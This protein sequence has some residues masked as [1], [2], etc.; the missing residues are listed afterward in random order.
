MQ[1]NQHI[2]KYNVEFNRL[3]IR[4]GWD[5]SVLRHRYYTG[6]AERIKDVMGPQGKPSTLDAMKT[7]AHSIDSRHWERQREKSRAGKSKA[8]GKADKSDK[9][10]HK[11]DHKSDDK[12]GSTS[13]HNN[14]KHNKDKQK[15]DSKSSS[16]NAPAYAEKLGKD[17]KLTQAERQ[18]RFDNNLCMF[19]GGVGH[20]AKDCPKSSSSASKAKA[21]AAQVKEKE[22]PDPKKG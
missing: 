1:D 2:V 14:H 9:P 21:R 20:G 22:T 12:K 3:A 7:L 11:S 13:K 4:T 8:D 19:C 6:L 18:R 5:D 16:G 17:G 15:N 10:D